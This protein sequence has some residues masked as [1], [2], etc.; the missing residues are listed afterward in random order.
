M[1]PPTRQFHRLSIGQNM[2]ARDPRAARAGQDPSDEREESESEF[3]EEESSE[4]EEEEEE[5]AGVS[6]ILARSGITYDLSKLDTE[7]EAQ[8]L[9]GLDEQLDVVNCRAASGGYDFQLMDR[10]R[11]HIGKD[12]SSCTCS[13]FKERPDAACHHIFQWILDQ[14]HGCFLTKPPTGEVALSHDGR[15]RS[16]TPIEDLLEGQLEA[17]T[18]RLNWQYLREEGDGRRTGM[19]RAEKVRDVMS[20]FKPNVLPEGFRQDLVNER[21]TQSRTPEQCVVQGDLEATLF[22]LAVHDDS[23]FNNLCKAMPAGA[24]AAIY[25]DKI[26]DQC[27]RLLRDFDRYCMTGERPGSSGIVEV[28]EVAAQLRRLVQHIRMNIALRTPHGAE[29][30]AKAL[31]SVLEAVTARNKDPLEG[32]QWGKTSFHGEDED[33][34]NLYHLLIGS[35]DMNLGP[36]A[37]LFVIDALAS[38]APSDLH[39]FINQLQAIRHRI[40]VNRAPRAYLLRLDALVRTAESA[41]AELHG[42]MALF[43]QKRPATGGSGGY[44]KRR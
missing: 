7:S 41:S 29:G 42:P 18:G 37:E 11:V 15:P 3:S 16:G 44:S 32:N 27:R 39:Q 36:E 12:A 26:Q 28:D 33:Q 14:L 34:R 21:T 1:P 9:V 25:F 30:A 2:P 20:A 6:T 10:P 4:E 38:L 17:V 5:E 19:T 43:G 31:V 8:A 23:V 35:E 40:E 24:C 22:R 13:T